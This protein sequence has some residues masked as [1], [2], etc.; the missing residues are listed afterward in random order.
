MTAQIKE[1]KEKEIESRIME[2][3]IE[4]AK[5][6]QEGLNPTNFYEKGGHPAEGLHEG[7]AR[8]RRRLFRLIS[9][10]TRISVGALIS[11]VSGKGIPASLVMVMIRTVFTSYVSR[12]DVSCAGVVRA[13]NEALTVDFAMDKFATLFFLIYNRKTE[14]LP[15]RMRVTG[16]FSATGRR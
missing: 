8:G 12:G 11:D 3:Q 9:T 2:E 15:F 10:S 5:E 6:I 1:A 13:I 4:M 7:G 14:E 16:P